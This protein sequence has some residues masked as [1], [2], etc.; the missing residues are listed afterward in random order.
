MLK[1]L[2]TKLNENLVMQSDLHQAIHNIY[3][4]DE[5]DIVAGILLKLVNNRTYLE[6]VN[7]LALTDSINMLSYLPSKGNDKYEWDKTTGE[8]KVDIVYNNPKRIQVRIGR[9]VRKIISSLSVE[10][11]TFNYNGDITVVNWTHSTEVKIPK[12]TPIIFINGHTTFEYDIQDHK[13]NVKYKGIEKPEYLISSA[14]SSN[15]GSTLLTFEVFDRIRTTHKDTNG[16]IIQII[17]NN[18]D[19]LSVKRGMK[20]SNFSGKFTLKTDLKISDADIEKFYNNLS[21]IIKLS[22]PSEDTSFELVNGQDIAKYYDSNSYQMRSGN[23]GSSCMAI[24]DISDYFNIYV[25]NPNQ[26]SLLILR[27]NTNDKI[28]GRAIVWNLE[29][30]KFMDRVYA[31]NVIDENLFTDY[32]IKNEWLYRSNNKYCTFYKNGGKQPFK[33]LL[34]K[35]NKSNFKHYPYLDTLKYLNLDKNILTNDDDLYYDYELTSI[36]GKWADYEDENDDE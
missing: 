22:R 32:A 21:T 9:L 11:N 10:N 20:T 16:H 15:A 25:M 19:S 28:L 31:L 14:I 13:T 27:N 3:D 33:R 24:E 17:D 18:T 6:D 2:T 12:Y 29:D 35:L 26:I 8:Y 34:I 7:F 23:L 5:D 36:N 1:K 4:R 30:G